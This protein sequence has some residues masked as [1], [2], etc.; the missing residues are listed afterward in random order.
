[1]YFINRLIKTFSAKNAWSRFAKPFGILYLAIERKNLFKNNLH[2]T[3]K[4]FPKGE[5]MAGFQEGR[6]ADG[7]GN[8][9]SEPLMG[10]VGTRFGRNFPIDKLVPLDKRRL[11]EPNPR[12]ISEKLLAR[13][14]FVPATT[15]NMLAAVWIQF[16]VHDWFG[17]HRLDPKEKWKIPLAPNDSFP[18]KP[19]MTIEKSQPDENQ[20]DP[21]F[22]AYA[23]QNSH[24]WDATQ[25]YGPTKEKLDLLRAFK[26]GKL[27]IQENGLLC[28]DG[29]CGIDLTGIQE[30]W[31]VG[32]SVLHS[33][34]VR[35][36]NTICDML[37]EKYPHFDDEMLFQKARLINSA[38]IAKIHT[39]EWTPGILD[40]PILKM[41]MNANWYGLLGKQIKKKFKTPSYALS[42]F[43][44]NKQSH[45]GVPYS[46]TE[47]F[48]SVYRLHSLLP[49]FLEI[50]SLS[51][52]KKLEDIPMQDT[53]NK[54]SRA[55]LEKF[56]FC[57]LLY[58]LGTTHPGALRLHNYP[59]FLRELK[60]ID[61]KVIDLA[62]ID[63]LRDR[64]RQVP[65]YN[66]FRRLLG[67]IPAKSFEDLAH[68][69]KTAKDL[70]E[71]YENVEEVD[72]LTG[73]LA[74]K[75]P[76]GYGFGDTAFQIFVLMASRRFMSDRFF[77]V[78]YR[79]E[80][81]TQ[82]GIDWVENMDFKAV[83][84]RHCPQLASPLEGIVNPFAPW[85]K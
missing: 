23:N 37:K 20:D 57:D 60:R 5:P 52:G 31:W 11:L 43:L 82:E 74:E 64:E 47:E 41:G 65:R 67:L 7:T 53:V 80:I 70:S 54:K 45:A 81:Y 68:D 39:L 12:L 85:K 50:S 17:I 71:V 42:G 59:N 27:K 79:K 75:F 40:N 62:S 35:E 14:N 2:S 29:T 26:D 63:I 16:M 18:E 1:M 44:G 83:C 76:H 46:I 36:H 25:L 48:I 6:T 8:D 58:S 33:L 56:D 24:W 66:D 69:E 38:L 9:I 77:G 19:E 30:N 72:L 22:I 15:L 13:E 28:L 3:Y 51:T 61:G 32:L 49:D 78:D 34:F 84:L 73:C 55:V 4:Q 21:R 10:A